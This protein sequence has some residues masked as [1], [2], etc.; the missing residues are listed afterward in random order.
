M[1]YDVISSNI[2]KS[3]F[4]IILFVI[5]ILAMG[6][7]FGEATGSGVF[8][9]IIAV[10]IS[11]FMVFSSYYYSDKIILAISRAIPVNPK[12]YPYLYNTVE[13]LSIAAGIPVPKI[14]LID[15]SAPNAFATGR[16]PKN[17][18]IVFTT[19]LIEK[20][21]RLELEGVIS[22]EMSHI[23]NYDILKLS[24]GRWYFC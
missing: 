7:V 11:I 8:G 21:D 1:I 5:F 17:S 16:N 20:L 13:G 3:I 12:E 14:Y 24:K 10:V 4:I 19:G 15:D 18:S 22:H 23:K 9:L 6:Y 2:N